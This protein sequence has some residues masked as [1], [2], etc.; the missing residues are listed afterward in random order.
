MIKS[1]R[2]LRADESE[3]KGNDIIVPDGEIAIIKTRGGGIRLKVGDGEKK[4]SELS[5]IT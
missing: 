3:W 5:A 1:I 4:F 2:H